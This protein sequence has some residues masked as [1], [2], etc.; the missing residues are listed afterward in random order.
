[1]GGHAITG[2]NDAVLLEK[3][4]ALSAGGGTDLHGGLVAGYEQAQSAYST[5]KINRIILIS[6]G[7]ANV[8]V[9]DIDIIAENAGGNGEDGIYM[10]G[11]G[12]GSADSYH[13]DLMDRVTDAGK[14]ASVFI[15]NA[16]EAGKVFG[17][18]FINTL[19]VAARDV[20]VKLDL[21]PG[22]E[23]VRFGGE[24]YSDD[25]T[26]I[27]PQ[28]LA[29]NDTM[30]FHQRIRTC[31]P[32][33]V[34]E[35]AAIGVEVRYKNAVTF[36]PQMMVQSVTFTQLLGQET[37]LLHKGMAVLAYTDALDARRTQSS[38]AGSLITAA[39]SQIAAAAA[40][41]DNDPDL[42]EMQAVLDALD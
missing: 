2:P 35:D 3:A 22:F 13:D 7:G 18:Q 37:P 21:P 5:D 32:E 41:L 15:P 26:E 33:L 39:K 1:M 14:G 16:D 19:A 4:D 23:I 11:V 12:V 29:P 10:V 6:D 31:A 17:D 25:P 40:L 20:Q 9:T 28:H 36:D 27:E 24:E 8:G 38:E 34:D 42:Q 30:V